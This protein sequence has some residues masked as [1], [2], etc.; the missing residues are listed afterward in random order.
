MI[1]PNAKAYGLKEYII[2]NDSCAEGFSYNLL[3]VHFRQASRDCPF[4]RL[5]SKWASLGQ[6]VIKFTI[7]N[8][9]TYLCD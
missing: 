5:K 6:S 7:I 2:A 4:A 8:Y 1:D 3:R 9:V